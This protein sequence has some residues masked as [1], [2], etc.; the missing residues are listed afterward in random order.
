[1]VRR[2]APP[3]LPCDADIASFRTM[4]RRLRD[5]QGEFGDL[6]W[7]AQALTFAAVSGVA[8]GVLGP[9]GSFLN[10]NIV[11]RI[12][13]WA[14]N[15]L[16]GTVILG[17]IVPAVTQLALRLKLPRLLGV[18]VGVLVATAPAAIFS[19]LYGHWLWPYA[20]DRVRPEDW[21]GQALIIE[22]A[23]L[24]LWGL[25]MLAR[26][27]LQPL[28][29]PPQAE[30][31]VTDMVSPVL[32]LQMEDHYVRIH[33]ASGSRLELMTMAEAIARHGAGGL[34][35][36]R[37][38]WVADRAVAVAVLEGRNWRLRLSNGLNVPVARASVADA[39][40]RGW[41]S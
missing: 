11:L 4:N 6:R 5:W 18:A 28:P 12:F 9:F 14:G 3:A 16:A 35:V 13:S 33:R 2:D 26:E 29:Q 1:M 41:I 24:V 40:A 31:H 20:I 19:D 10:G 8:L 7:W 30:P 25:V 39:R 36:H 17:V 37:S 34:R 38:W 15:L 27:A 32:C 23:M 21:F 22:V